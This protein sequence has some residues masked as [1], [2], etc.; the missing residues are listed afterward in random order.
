MY[1]IHTLMGKNMIFEEFHDYI[2]KYS[3]V[4][5]E[6]KILLMFQFIYMKHTSFLSFFASVWLTP[7]YLDIVEILFLCSVFARQIFIICFSSPLPLP[8]GFVFDL[9]MN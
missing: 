9:C 7:K 6:L 1:E 8:Q 4:I 2:S 3:V 5:V